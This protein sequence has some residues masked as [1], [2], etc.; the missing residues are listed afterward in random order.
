[1]VGEDTRV[2]CRK[3]EEIWLGLVRAQFVNQLTT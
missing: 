3:W 1:M 2:D